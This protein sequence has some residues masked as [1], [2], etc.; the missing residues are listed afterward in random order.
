MRVPA[1]G[2]IDRMAHLLRYSRCTQRDALKTVWHHSDIHP[3]LDTQP[4]TKGAFAKVTLPVSEKCAGEI[5]T[6]PCH[7]ELTLDKVDG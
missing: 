2:G 5:L 7:P 3:I 1:I 6:L 4:V